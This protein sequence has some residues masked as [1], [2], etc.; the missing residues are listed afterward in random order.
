M[1][2]AA[3]GCTMPQSAGMSQLMEYFLD[4]SREKCLLGGAR[5][6][7]MQAHD[8]C[9]AAHLS[10]AEDEVQIAGITIRLGDADDGPSVTKRHA[11][12]Q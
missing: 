5:T 4:R 3:S 9:A 11:L 8:G 7:P 6:Q 2:D 12:E 1:H 10:N